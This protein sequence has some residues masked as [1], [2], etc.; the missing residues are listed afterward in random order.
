MIPVY[1]QLSS[2]LRTTMY[3]RYLRHTTRNSYFTILGEGRKKIRSLP[4]PR[5]DTTSP[6]LPAPAAPTRPKR[7]A[8]AARRCRK[9][10]ARRRMKRTA[11]RNRTL[12]TTVTREGVVKMY[13]KMM[14]TARVIRQRAVIMNALI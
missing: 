11:R 14:K 6:R 4:I 12:I 3:V 9:R 8:S 1:V 10:A 2:I 7:A 5:Q 13:Q